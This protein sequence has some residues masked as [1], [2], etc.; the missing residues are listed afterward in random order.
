MGGFFGVA[1]KTDCILDL[2]YGVDYHSHLGIS[3]FNYLCIG[4]FVFFLELKVDS[5]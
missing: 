2:F 1:A 4:F 5:F 3:K